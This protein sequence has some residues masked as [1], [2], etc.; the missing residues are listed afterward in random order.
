MSTID[1]LSQGL[2]E[3]AERLSEGWQHLW[4]SARNAITRYTPGDDADHPLST[5]RAQWGV[6]SAEVRETDDAVEVVLEAPG[7]ENDDFI[8]SAR[9]QVLSVS[10]EKRMNRERTEGQY[11][12][13]E[14]AYGRFE[15]VIALPARVDESGARAQY[16]QGVLT[17]T[18]PKDA[19]SKVRRITV[20]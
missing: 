6:M 3:G 20:A 14:R 17:V 18:L 10:G 4:T 1:H 8:L 7:M 12:V 19:R 11:H 15:R 9:D 16:R 2:R 13:R 5:R